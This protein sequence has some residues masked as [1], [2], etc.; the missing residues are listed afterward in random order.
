MHGPMN[1]KKMKIGYGVVTQ[2]YVSFLLM[3]MLAGV[4][5]C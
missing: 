1:V 4:T 3:M 5:N 2:N